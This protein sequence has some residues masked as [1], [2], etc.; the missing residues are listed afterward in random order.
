MILGYDFMKKYEEHLKTHPLSI[1]MEGK[2]VKAV[3]LSIEHVLHITNNS[4]IAEEIT[5]NDLVPCTVDE[6]QITKQQNAGFVVLKTKF[7][8]N[9]T[10]LFEP[11]PGNFGTHTL[12]PGLVRL[13]SD[14]DNKKSRFMI[15]YI[16]VELQDICLEPGRVLGYI[17]PCVKENLSGQKS[18]VNAMTEIN[19]EE[20]QKGL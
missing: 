7:V 20:R 2:D 12:C 10:A 17:Q 14:K 18:V 3:E 1:S 16:N 15:K 9:D 5:E 13:E 11:V 6:A 8:D 19:E 4:P